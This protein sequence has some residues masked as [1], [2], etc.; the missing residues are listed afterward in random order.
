MDA[1]GK[2]ELLSKT[3]L[4]SDLTDPILDAIAGATIETAFPAGKAIFLRGDP[5]DAIYVVRDG[6]VRLS[7]LTSD[8]REL[9]FAHA[10]S[11]DVFGEIAVIDKATRSADATALMDVR[12]LTL[13]ATDVEALIEKFPAIA[14]AFMKFLCARLRDVS[15]HLE[16]IALLSLEARLARFLLDKI[17][18]AS[19]LSGAMR[20]RL[21]LGMSQTEL[22]LLLSA[23]RQK[24]N[25]ALASLEHMGAIQRSA[26]W[27][28]CSPEKLRDAARFD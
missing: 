20:P 27:L 8:G 21:E 5:G 25:H 1:N 4:F 18:S 24:V 2:R 15:D 3:K 6:R 19:P 26:G 11:G 12:L 10:Q 14:R 17:S 23:S 16:H 13:H 7:V 28:Y 22:G 9:S